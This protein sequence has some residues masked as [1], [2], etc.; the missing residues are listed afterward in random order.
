MQQ[1]ISIDREQPRE[2]YPDIG[3]NL[4]L[5]ASE[6]WCILLRK[7]STFE[8]QQVGISMEVVSGAT[9]QV[10]DMQAY[11]SA[12]VV[13]HRNAFNIEIDGGKARRL[14]TG[15][16]F[17]YDQFKDVVAELANLCSTMAADARE[18]EAEKADQAKNSQGPSTS[19]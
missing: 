19:S 7:P 18:E 17:D 6:R 1:T 3:G 9:R 2:F 12:F 8:L 13:R 16:L 4:E 14:N 15:D 11:Y 5:P 10:F